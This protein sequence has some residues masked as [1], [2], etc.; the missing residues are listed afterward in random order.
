MKNEETPAKKDAT[1]N[2]KKTLA[3]TAVFLAA[4]GSFLLSAGVRL[5]TT[6]ASNEGVKV[7]LDKFNGE[8]AQKAADECARG[9]MNTAIDERFKT[10]ETGSVVITLDDMLS[11]SD[12]C[13][14]E[15]GTKPGPFYSDPDREFKLTVT[16]P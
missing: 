4:A 3:I 12:A 15:T 16:R 6:V 7:I 8:A 14:K 13:E 2:T 1:S 10:P 5:A 9:R 11:F